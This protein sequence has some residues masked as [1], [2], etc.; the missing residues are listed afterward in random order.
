M[1][2]TSGTDSGKTTRG[3]LVDRE[4]PGLAGLVPP[5]VARGD[6]LTVEQLTE[7]LDVEAGNGMG[8][9]GHVVHLSSFG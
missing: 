8:Q 6:D 4:I 7:R 3:A 1:A 5:F 2:T 9:C